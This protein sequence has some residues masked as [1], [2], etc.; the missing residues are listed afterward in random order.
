M[1]Q[2]ITFKR[3]GRKHMDLVYRYLNFTIKDLDICYAIYED[4][5]C[6]GQ[7]A[8]LKKCKDYV[9]SLCQ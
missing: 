5:K 6:L 3:E 9:R 2:K 8:S 7:S 1:E 4:D